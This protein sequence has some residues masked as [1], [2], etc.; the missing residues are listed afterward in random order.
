MNKKVQILASLDVLAKRE[1][2]LAVK[3]HKWSSNTL[4]I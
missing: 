3:S 2:F 4:Q 1:L